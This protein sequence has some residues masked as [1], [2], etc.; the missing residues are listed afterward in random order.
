MKRLITGSTLTL[1]MAASAGVNAA[2]ETY[3]FDKPHTNIM[4]SVGHLGL[5]NFKGQF[6]EYDGTVVFDQED[7]TN[8]SVRVT[9]KTASVD[10]DVAALD[11]HLLNA[12]FFDAEKYPEI[13]FESTKVEKVYKD[14]FYITGNLSMHGVTKAV[15]LTARLNYAGPHPLAKFNEKY[16]DAYYAGFAAETTLRRSEFGIDRYVPMVSDEVRLIIDVELRRQ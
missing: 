15:T 2:P 14:Q 7:V 8:S 4:F 16:K 13:R 5:S 6:Q 12:D 9:I 3:S 1:L 10:T 11:E